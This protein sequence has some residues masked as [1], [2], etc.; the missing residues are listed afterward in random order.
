MSERDLQQ[1]SSTV[2]V[3]K[4]LALDAF[5]DE[6]FGIDQSVKLLRAQRL[7]YVD[8]ASQERMYFERMSVHNT[9]SRPITASSQRV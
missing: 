9:C 7:G 6:F 5:R 1:W 2:I 3:D 4:A 8:R